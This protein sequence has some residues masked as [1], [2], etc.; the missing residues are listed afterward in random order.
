MIGATSTTT[1]VDTQTD[2]PLE[3]RRTTFDDVPDDSQT[4]VP[5]TKTPD[6]DMLDAQQ[7]GRMIEQQQR[8]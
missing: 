1:Q 4:Q 7:P 8:E 3:L 2:S 5:I 6:D